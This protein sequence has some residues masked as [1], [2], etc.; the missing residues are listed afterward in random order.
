LRTLEFKSCDFVWALIR[1]LKDDISGEIGLRKSQ[2]TKL[3]FSG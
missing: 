1:E 3:P 2:I